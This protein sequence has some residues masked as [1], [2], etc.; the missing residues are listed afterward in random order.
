MYRNGR[1]ASRLA[2]GIYNQTGIPS[3]GWYRD[4]ILFDSW[5]LKLATE[6]GVT[7]MIMRAR[8]VR[9]GG[10]SPEFGGAFVAPGTRGR[11]RSSPFIHQLRQQRSLVQINRPQWLRLYIV[12]F[13]IPGADNAYCIELDR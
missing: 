6:E 5:E 13:W 7:K 11:C 3:S 12:Y 2:E 4:L 10:V 1:R 9:G 8:P